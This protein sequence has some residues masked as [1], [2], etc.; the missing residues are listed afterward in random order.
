MYYIFFSS[1]YLSN[2][3][4][5]PLPFSSTSFCLVLLLSTVAL[6]S[7]ISHFLNMI[8]TSFWWYFIFMET[9]VKKDFHCFLYN[10]SIK[11][12]PL[13]GAYYFSFVSELLLFRWYRESLLIQQSRYDLHFRFLYARGVQY[14]VPL[15][16]GTG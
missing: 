5:K 7:F 16:N 13:L 15:F 12:S 10:L 2:C 9:F 4:H 3:G 6:I 14:A 8:S 1:M 11:S